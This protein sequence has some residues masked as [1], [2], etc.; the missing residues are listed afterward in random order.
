MGGHLNAYL[1]REQTMYFGKAFRGDV[2]CAVDILADILLN[3]RLNPGSISRERDVI[4]REIKE[5][6]WHKEELVLYPPMQWCSTAWLGNPFRIP[7]NSTINPI[8]DLLNSGI[9]ICILFF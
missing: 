9:F 4:L 1:S 5:E 6:N 7:R 3:S 8:L 2:S